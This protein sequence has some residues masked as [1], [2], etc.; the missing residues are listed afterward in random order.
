VV[1]SD[2]VEMLED[3]VLTACNEDI[4]NDEEETSDKIEKL[5]DGYSKE[6]RIHSIESLS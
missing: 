1:N 3:L 5:T 2:N 4:K 6:L